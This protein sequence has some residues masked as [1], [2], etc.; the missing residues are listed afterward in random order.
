M[1]YDISG[2]SLS[3]LYS[4]SGTNG[5]EFDNADNNPL[6][7]G[8][9]GV[10][11]GCSQG[12]GNFSGTGTIFKINKDG[13]S[14]QTL[15]EFNSGLA[16]EGFSP[17]GGFIEKN[18]LFYSSTPVEDEGNSGTLFTLDPANA[19]TVDFVHT[20]EIFEGS[21]PK[22]TFTESTNGRLYLTCSG[23]TGSI[24]EYNTING[25]VTQRHSFSTADGTKPQFDGLC[26]VDLSSL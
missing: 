2:A 22:G 12:G 17:Q 3:I 20:L 11:Y 8:P 10:L 9:S 5:N 4:S 25:N 19:N 6:I 18:G 21:Q 1:K 15:F 16:D 14:Y 24:I 7:E 23:G 26:I 13:T